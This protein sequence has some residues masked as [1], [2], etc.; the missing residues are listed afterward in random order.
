MLYGK[1]EQG[2]IYL[3]GFVPKLHLAKGAIFTSRPIVSWLLW[4]Y[5]KKRVTSSTDLLSIRQWTKVEIDRSFSSNEVQM[6][7]P[8]DMLIHF[9]QGVHHVSRSD[10]LCCQVKFYDMYSTS[11]HHIEKQ[12]ASA[13]S[14]V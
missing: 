14:F 12:F 7:N 3:K 5:K 11:N 4:S 1:W 2:N 6:W 8:L 13:G 9:V 10:Q